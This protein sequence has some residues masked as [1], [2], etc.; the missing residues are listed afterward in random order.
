MAQHASVLKEGTIAGIL[1]AAGVAFWFLIV[2]LVTGRALATPEL[3]GQSL[4]SVLGKGIDWSPMQ[5]V[6]AYTVV[7]VAAF[8]IVGMVTVAIIHASNRTPG[9]LAGLVLL[10][11]VI[12]AGFY[13]LTVF[14]SEGEI[15]GNLAWYQ[16]GAANLLAAA[17][18]GGYLLREHPGL[19]EK[20]AGVLAGRV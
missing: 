12:E 8:A 6:L 2:D 16:I 13:G 18:M 1:G 7:H 20:T 19:G 14:L 17:L 4:F 15:L 3:L 5:Y 11:A 10:F 9:V